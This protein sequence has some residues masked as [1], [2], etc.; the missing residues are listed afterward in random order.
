MNASRAREHFS[1]YREGTL[2]AAL[3]MAFDRALQTDAQLQ[4]EYLAFQRALDD[5][6]FLKE[7]SIEP[8]TWLSDRIATRLEEAQSSRNKAPIWWTGWFRNVALG[9]LAVAA[10]GGAV[11]GIFT[12]G[13]SGPTQSG[14]IAI[15]SM[16]NEAKIRYQWTGDHLEADSDGTVTVQSGSLSSKFGGPT[17]GD[18]QNPNANPAVFSLQLDGKE[19]EIVVLPGQSLASESLRGDGTL[20]EF[21]QALASASRTPVRL[22]AEVKETRV[23]WDFSGN[24]PLD[25]ASTALKSVNLGVDKRASG[26]IALQ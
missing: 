16:T 12:K 11:A 4:A 24:N 17:K 8:P 23:S 1:A 6:D 5:L 26:E 22:P 10:I 13:G 7:E 19:F 25:D 18:L 15:P 14:P 2:D 9:G 3:R 20:V 21:A